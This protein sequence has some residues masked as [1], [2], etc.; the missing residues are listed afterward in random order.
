[1]LI[2]QIKEINRIIKEIQ[3][4]AT[5][6]FEHD[7]KKFTDLACLDDE[8]DDAKLKT[9]CD[10]VCEPPRS[11]AICVKPPFVSAC[12]KNLEGRDV[13]VSAAIGFPTGDAVLKDLRKTIDVAI[14]EGAKEIDLVFPYQIYLAGHKVDAYKRFEC[15][16]DHIARRVYTKVIIESGAFSD[17]DRIYEIACGLIDLNVDMIKTSSGYHEKGASLEAVAA[18]LLAIK[19]HDIGAQT[20]IKISGGVKICQEA[21]YYTALYQRIIGR[22]WRDRMRLRFGASQWIRRSG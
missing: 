6:V 12:R 11:T 22:D 13:C 5:E 7:L 8:I 18:I 19:N 1:M 17:L 2:E 14:I 21:S 3:I 9:L 16:L 10:A 20:G 15:L 4:S